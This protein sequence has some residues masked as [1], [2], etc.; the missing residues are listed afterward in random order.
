MM[1]K[2]EA[3]CLHVVV[4]GKVNA[5]TVTNFKVKMAARPTSDHEDGY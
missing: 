1:Q 4:R 2:G 5:I 3:R